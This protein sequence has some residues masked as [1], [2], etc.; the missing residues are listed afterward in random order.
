[1]PR[2]ALPSIHARVAHAAPSS[3]EDPSLVQLWGPRFQVY[4][5]AAR[6]VRPV[7]VRIGA[8]RRR[9]V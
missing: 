9:G 4:V 3:W 1:M 6:G 8:R 5:V 2:A 7:V